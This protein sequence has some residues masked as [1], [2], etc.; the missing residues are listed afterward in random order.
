MCLPG[1]LGC[2]TEFRKWEGITYDSKN[3][4]IYTALSAVQYGMEDNMKNGV[5]NTM[6]DLGGSNHLK[7]KHN[8]C[9]CVMVMDVDDNFLATKAKMLACGTLNVDEA[10]KVPPP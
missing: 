2:T 9:G 7:M 8:T 6:Y 4:K 10:T 3:K 5:A 1:Y